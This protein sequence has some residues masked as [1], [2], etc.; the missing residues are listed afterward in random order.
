MEEHFENNLNRLTGVTLKRPSGQN[1]HCA[2]AYDALGR[3]TSKQAVTTV[4]GAPQ[5][6]TTFSLPS[7]DPTKV[8]AMAQAQTSDGLFPSATQTLTHTG[9]DKVSTLKQGNDSIRITYGYDR[10][11]ISMQELT[12]GTSR[13]KDYAGSC[14]FITASAL[15]GTGD[16]SLTYLSG[17]YGV[18]AVVESHNGSESLHYILKDN[19]GSWTTITNGTGTIEQRLSYDAWGN[20][21]NPNTW[22]GSFTGRPM[23]DR[24]F[25]GHEHAY[26]FGLINMN[27]RMY[28]PVTSSFLSVDQYVQSPDNAQGF[29]RYAYCMN[30]PLRYVDP[31]GWRPIEGIGGYTPN[32]SANAF[33]PYMFY[34]GRIPLEPRD[35]GLRELSTADP[36]ITWMEE[37][38]LHSSGNGGVK[39]AGDAEVEVIKNTLPK[40]ARAFVQL[41]KNGFIDKELLN[42]YQG[43]SLNFDNLKTLVNSDLIVEIIL[44]D[45]FTFMDSNGLIGVATMSYYPFDPSFPEDID[46]TGSTINGLSTGENGHLGQTLFPDLDG[47]QNSP[48]ENIIVVINKYLSDA[49]SAETYSHEANGHALLYI[50]N[51]GDHF[52]ASHQPINGGFIEGNTTLRIMI[53]NSKMETIIN[54]MKP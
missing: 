24:G 4:N 53:I 5:A 49:G 1:L 22:T 34:G 12:P 28:D 17:P 40:D 51:G 10:Q 41:D 16:K 44:D 46:V 37:N 9:F 27:G 33:D 20:L 18:F 52:G 35:L 45:H 31:S 42:L 50:L 8:H 6:T 54:M 3:M 30:N 15:G 13:K 39:P 21:R 23:F 47:M 14:E 26:A 11:R 36:I 32:S 7:F 48:N 19:L 38:S 25:T 2:V 29:N 43:K